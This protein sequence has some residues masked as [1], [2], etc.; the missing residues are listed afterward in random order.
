MN[1]QSDGGFKCIKIFLTIC[2]S[3]A[4]AGTALLIGVSIMGLS[5]LGKIETEQ[6]PQQQQQGQQ[7]PGQMKYSVE[8][9][10]QRK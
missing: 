8:I 1:I 6:Q 3:L 7:Y 4:I 2:Y 10:E 9:E 5:A